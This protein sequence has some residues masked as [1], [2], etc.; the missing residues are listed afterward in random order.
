MTDL[1]VDKDLE[2][3]TLSLTARFDAPIERIWEMW[4]DPRL[5]ERWWGPPT[6]PA[7]FEAHDL[8][9]GGAVSYYMTG[10]EGERYHGWWR[11]I[12]VDAPNRLT[13]EDGFADDDSK[14][15][16][17]LPTIHIEV[18]L[19]SANGRT[20]MTVLDT[21]SSIEAMEETLAMG[22][23]EGFVQAIGQI[24]DLLDAA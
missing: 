21:F 5:L 1:T 18:T 23:E 13:F 16:P 2:A 20:T 17:D 8:T 10:P 19:E 11:V 12:S 3:L 9:P 7:T 6:H 14:P 24:Y 15:N 4:A 22:A